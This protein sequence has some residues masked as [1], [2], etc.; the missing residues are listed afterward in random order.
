M[1]PCRLTLL[2]PGSSAT[3]I[4]A[5]M[6]LPLPRTIPLPLARGR[7]SDMPELDL[8]GRAA[9]AGPIPACAP[10]PGSSSEYIESLMSHVE[11]C[12]HDV[13]RICM[14]QDFHCCMGGGDLKTGL[15]SASLLTCSTVALLLKVRCQ[16]EAAQ[17]CDVDSY[18][19]MW[20]LVH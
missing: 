16:A 3:L 6:R 13:L 4:C 17:H 10:S 5:D 12:N 2:L 14:L 1:L 11:A 8:A 18:A 20:E 19:K 9:R 7:V 15:Q